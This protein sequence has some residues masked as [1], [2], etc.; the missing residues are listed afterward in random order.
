MV[1]STL[2]VRDL[3]SYYFTQSAIIKAV[4]GISFT[5]EKGE[6]LGIVGESGSGKS[7]IGW[8]IMRTLPYPGKIVN[9]EIFYKK[10]NI[11]ELDMEEL[12]KI[13]GKKISMITQSAMNA[14]DPLMRVGDQIIEAILVHED[15][16]KD[17]AAKR[18]KK[19]FEEVRLEASRFKSYPHELS[20]GM[21]QRTMIAM[22]LAC[23]PGLIIADEPT[24][25]LDVIVQAQIL[26]LLE[27]LQY[28]TESSS[29]MFI[30]HDLSVIAELCAK[31]L[32]MYGGKMM[33]YASTQTIIKN[34]LHPYTKGL[35][36]CFPKIEKT[37]MRFE[38]IPG[39][40]PDMIHLPKGCIFHPRCIYAKDICRTVAP[41]WVNVGDN[42]WVACHLI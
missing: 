35:L 16:P 3:K 24:T 12:R 21:K 40:I 39:S 36:N 38:S 8:S 11:L 1:K 23:E 9:G 26:K 14:L 37:E 25:A 33:E 27:D 19:I 20:G 22:A 42:H 30:S 13:R 2:E 15:I 41:E 6:A 17:I 7:T 5:I 18:A 10:R 28:S 32:I 31:T 34:P 29:I 4:D